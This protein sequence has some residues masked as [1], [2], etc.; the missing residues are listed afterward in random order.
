MTIITPL[1]TKHGLSVGNIIQNR[2][3][4]DHNSPDMGL[5]SPCLTDN[6]IKQFIGK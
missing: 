4:Y 6:I 3:Q 1:Q 2:V 5:N